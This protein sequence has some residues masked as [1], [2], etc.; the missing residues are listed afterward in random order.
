MIVL[1]GIV[2]KSLFHAHIP[3]QKEDTF[4]YLYLLSDVPLQNLTVK[5]KFF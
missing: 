4:S 5:I 2:D 1:S 3:V